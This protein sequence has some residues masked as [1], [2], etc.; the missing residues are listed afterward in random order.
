MRTGAVPS[1]WLGLART[2]SAQEQLDLLAEVDRCGIPH[3]NLAAVRA[4][5]ELLRHRR[6]LERLLM[7]GDIQGGW[8]APCWREAEDL[9]RWS[10]FHG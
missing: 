2:I 6:V 4:I 9:V 8:E 3:D 10:G 7:W 5:L 1:T